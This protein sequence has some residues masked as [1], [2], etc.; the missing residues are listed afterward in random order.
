MRLLVTGGRHYQDRAFAFW[1][2]D[3]VA[4]LYV[5][6]VLIHGGAEGADRLA[7]EW[8]TERAI[9]VSE[10]PADWAGMGRRAGP[11]R[12]W[13]MLRDG[14]PDF[15]VAFEGDKGTEHMCSIAWGARVP[16][17]RPADNGDIPAPNRP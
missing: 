16:I 13:R 9:E 3:C 8:A 6:D 11:M 1:A 4:D 10:Y 12:N 2:L 14:K 17:W 5:V 15:V 7:A